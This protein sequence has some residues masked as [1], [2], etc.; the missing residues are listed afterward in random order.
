MPSIW[1]HTAEA[2]SSCVPL[3]PTHPEDRDQVPAAAIPQ[4]GDQRGLPE[5]KANAGVSAAHLPGTRAQVAHAAA[6]PPCQPSRFLHRLLDQ[7]EMKPHS[8][9]SPKGHGQ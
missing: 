2:F 3:S 6:R 9:C 4:P 8:R 5:K 1:R 7:K